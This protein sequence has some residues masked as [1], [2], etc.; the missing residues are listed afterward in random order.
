[1]RKIFIILALTSLLLISAKNVKLV[2]FEVI[3]KSGIPIDI[4]LDGKNLKQ[5]YYLRIPQGNRIDPIEMSFT[6]ATDFYNTQVYYLAPN[7]PGAVTVCKQPK[8]TQLDITHNVRFVVLECHR[9]PIYTG[10]LY[11]LKFPVSFKPY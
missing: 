7:E 9:A 2:R 11:M 3:N 1:M 8:P 5:F 4:R 10:E 6:V